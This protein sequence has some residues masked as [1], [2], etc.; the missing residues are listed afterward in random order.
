MVYMVGFKILLQTTFKG[1]AAGQAIC[2]LLK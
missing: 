1:T 2:K